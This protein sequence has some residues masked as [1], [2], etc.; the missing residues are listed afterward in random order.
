MLSATRLWGR[1]I[2]ARARERTM[3]IDGSDDGLLESQLIFWAFVFALLL[4]RAAEDLAFDAARDGRRIMWGRPP[5]VVRSGRSLARPCIP[6]SLNLRAVMKT[7]RFP[8]ARQPGAAV[9]TGCLPSGGLFEDQ[10]FAKDQVSNGAV[11]LRSSR[12]GDEFLYFLSRP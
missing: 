9:P 10:I 12:R 4:Q 3:E 6:C 5:S 1:S 7:A 8:R 11:H 2:R